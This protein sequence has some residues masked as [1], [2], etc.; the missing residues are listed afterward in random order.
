M[1][2]DSAK[3]TETIIAGQMKEKW[4]ALTESDLEG[5]GGKKGAQTEQSCRSVM[6]TEKTLRNRK[7]TSSCETTPNRI[8]PRAHRLASWPKS[9][10]RSREHNDQ[11]LCR[12]VQLHRLSCCLMQ[13]RRGRSTTDTAG[14]LTVWIGPR[15]LRW[16]MPVTTAA[17]F[18]FLFL[19]W[20]GAFPSGYPAYTQNAFQTIAGSVSVDNPVAVEGRWARRNLR[21]RL[22][23]I[24][25]CFS[26]SCSSCWRS[27]WYSRT[28]C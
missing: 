25:S 1:T 23:W 21:Q 19:P 2:A 12:Q 28:L 17:L 15:L 9:N 3:T 27:S 8:L 20:T 16:I 6:D 18:V 11:R 26:T 7:P 13:N 24:R 22:T 4:G 10:R 5:I 14:Q